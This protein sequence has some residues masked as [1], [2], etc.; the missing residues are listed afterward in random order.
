MNSKGIFLPDLLLVPKIRTTSSIE[1]ISVTILLVSENQEILDSYLRN[2]SLDVSGDEYITLK[3]LSN[4][5][6]ASNSCSKSMANGKYTELKGVCFEGLEINVPEGMNPVLSSDNKVI[7]FE[8]ANVPPTHLGKPLSSESIDYL[9]SS[10]TSTFFDNEKEKVL[11]K[12]VLLQRS[13]GANEIFLSDVVKIMKTFIFDNSK[14]QSIRILSLFVKER[15]E[16]YRLLESM[17]VF[18]SHKEELRAIL[19]P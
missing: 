13:L 14:L 4:T 6:T 12:F 19:L 1:A 17:F 9:L 11:Q 5:S 15:P 2:W 7:T 3:I 18:Q 10:L 16:A 8:A